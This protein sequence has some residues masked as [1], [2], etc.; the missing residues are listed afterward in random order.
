M[1]TDGVP[2]AAVALAGA[3]NGQ[4]HPDHENGGMSTDHSVTAADRTSPPGSQD[5]PS[6]TDLPTQAEQEETSKV[7]I[8]VI[9][10]INI[11]EKWSSNLLF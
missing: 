9:T 4:E 6:L 8:I 3:S 7:L 11:T 1:S 5:I 10:N 2:T